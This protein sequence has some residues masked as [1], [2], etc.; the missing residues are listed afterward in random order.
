[1]ICIIYQLFKKKLVL[2]Y[3]LLEKS[4]CTKFAYTGKCLFLLYL[5]FFALWSVHC[6]HLGFLCIVPLSPSPPFPPIIP[7]QHACFMCHVPARAFSLQHFMFL[8]TVT[9]T[10]LSVHS[11]IHLPLLDVSLSESVTFSVYITCILYVHKCTVSQR[12]SGNTVKIQN[13]PATI[14]SNLSYLRSAHLVFVLNVK[15]VVHLR[16]FPLMCVC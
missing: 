8:V 13:L 11:F 5:P 12:I 14:A 16:L 10:S 1:M 9:V 6:H 3:S 15:C 2:S 4:F 7:S